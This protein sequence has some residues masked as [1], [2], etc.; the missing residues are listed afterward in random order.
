MTVAAAAQL[1]SPA[2]LEP[3]ERPVAAVVR[4]VGLAVLAGGVATVAGTVY[5]VYARE[6]M[7]EGLAV[8]VGLAV[9]GGWLNTTTALR[10]FLGTGDVV[11][12]PSVALVNSAAF[13]LGAAAAALG[14]RSGARV[15]AGELGADVG[16]LAGTVGRFV[17][18]DLP[19]DI[20]DVDG[21]EPLDAETRE[22]L[23]GATLR[24]PRGLTVAELRERLVARLRD[25]YDVGRVDVELAADG[26]VEYLAAG[27]RVAG[28][29]PTLA[30]GTVAVAV[31]ADPAAGASAGDVVQVRS[32]GEAAERVATAE[33]R[34]TVGDVATLALDA[35][36][37]RRIDPDAE[38]RLVTLPTEPR[39]DREFSAHLRAA[40]ET[41]GTAT[42]AADSSLVGA[43][44][45]SVDATVVA[46]RTDAGVETIPAD[47]RVLAAGDTLYVV[48]R[49]DLLRRI[50]AAAG[51]G[52]SASG[53][54]SDATT[55]RQ[56]D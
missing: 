49:P 23:A 46:V 32:T 40:D 51:S 30:P 10:Q 20:A 45:G 11:P 6:E 53:G 15:L 5:S 52:G 19:E 44:V 7:P 41:V 42:V 18:V 37:A 1:A 21:Y 29:G 26:T 54:R 39:A 34:A 55:I 9:V 35:T 22:T 4:V 31:R 27:G 47:D 3:F 28:L 13:V 50:E 2:V 33:L 8:L 24:F 14:A 56:G 25:D 12:S 48:G 38:Y 16:R 36:D 43:P 17:A